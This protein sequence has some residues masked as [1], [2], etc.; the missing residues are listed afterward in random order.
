MGRGVVVGFGQWVQ[1]VGWELGMDGAQQVGGLVGVVIR[2]GVVERDGVVAAV[3]EVE[4]RAR[5]GVAV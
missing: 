2:V 3:Q 4:E 1:F 5:G